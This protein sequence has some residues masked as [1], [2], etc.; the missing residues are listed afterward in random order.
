V[1]RPTPTRSARR[2]F[3]ALGFYRPHTPYVA[4]ARF[5]DRYPPDRVEVAV[6]PP[7]DRENKPVA[8][9]A[10]RPFQADM[11]EAQKRQAIQGYH[12]AISFMDEQLGKVLDSLQESGLAGDTIIGFTRVVAEKRPVRKQPAHAAHHGCARAARG[13][14]EI[15]HPG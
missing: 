5:F 2:F 11:T 7:G 9:L 6:V 14:R 10:D 12:A 13:G 1:T 4:P 3:L 8:A 15:G